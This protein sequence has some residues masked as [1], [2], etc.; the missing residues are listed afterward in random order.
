MAPVVVGMA[1]PEGSLFEFYRGGVWPNNSCALPTG[2][3]V[4]KKALINHAVLVV[5]YDMK[6]AGNHFWIVKNSWGAG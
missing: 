5:G 1:V 2:A 6:T 4:T 3:P